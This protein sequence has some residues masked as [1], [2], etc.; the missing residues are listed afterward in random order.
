MKNNLSLTS[1]MRNNLLSIRNIS[2]QMNSVQNIISTG[3]RVNSAIDN[4]SNYYQAS[5]LRYRA[6]ALN[7][8]L[9]NMG[10][11]IQIIKA[12]TEGLNTSLKILN[13][14]RTLA[15][16]TLSRD[17]TKEEN[18]ENSLLD[19]LLNEGYEIISSAM[20]VSEILA[21]IKEGAKLVLADDI[22]L[23]TTIA[24]NTNNVVINGNGKTI[25]Y[26]GNSNL[27]SI[28]GNNITITNVGIEYNNVIGGDVIKVDGAQASA[29]ISEIKIRSV[30]DA[31]YGIHCLNKADV[32]IDNT[33]GFKLLGARSQNIANGD[34]ELYDGEGNTNAIFNQVGNYSIIASAA[35]KFYV[36]N[37]DDT[38]FGQGT[39]YIPSLGEFAE[40]YGINENNITSGSGNSGATGENKK[41]INNA[42]KTLADKGVEAEEFYNTHYW[43]STEYDR[44]KTGTVFNM[45]DGG[46][47]HGYK[48]QGSYHVRLCQYVENCFNPLDKTIDQPKIGDVLYSDLSYGSADNYNNKT[49]VGIITWISED[50]KSAKIVNLKDLKFSS[51]SSINNFNEN[52]PYNNSVNI[53]NHTTASKCSET[54]KGLNKY[55]YNE[56][57]TALKS[58]GSVIV[59]QTIS[60]KADNIIINNDYYQSYSGFEKLINQYN[61]LIS[62]C[63][64]KGVNLL[65]GDNL[66]V[67]FNN[68]GSHKQEIFGVNMLNLISSV[69]SLEWENEEDIIATIN[70]IDKAID[71]I[72]KYQNELGN[73][74]NI[75]KTRQDF[76][77]AMINI[78]SEGADKLIL[79]DMNEASA[80]YLML[81]TRQM[82]A[83]N[84]LS[85]AANASRGILKLF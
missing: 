17:N 56:V 38:N 48:E 43:T 58:K 27:F 42:L 41:L 65:K 68:D 47:N 36:G 57:A 60:D 26:N 25:S 28:S 64:Y 61:Q 46:R 50:G 3:L 14:M 63:S 71:N 72:R 49:A 18:K 75:I 2:K 4:S 33:E 69:I 77:N 59:T 76:S 62:D 30:N 40:I 29:N 32:T 83:I 54:I 70:E 74:F 1:A 31:V 37:S 55:S 7:S 67:N 22:V 15:E 5:D 78:L 11:G 23:D 24:I 66:S 85:L 80:M 79:A 35:N 16:Q 44:V 84:A 45:G 51:S 19:E 81:Q 10:Q 6:S 9:D 20:D 73:S 52:N 13:Q 82:L 53:A 8:L 39:W 21:K 34:M 12:A